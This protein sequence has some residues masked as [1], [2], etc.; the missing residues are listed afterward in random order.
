MI[1]FKPARKV[2]DSMPAMERARTA[3]L[4]NVRTQAGANN[5]TRFLLGVCRA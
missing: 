4:L 2:S 3:A 5:T 1:K